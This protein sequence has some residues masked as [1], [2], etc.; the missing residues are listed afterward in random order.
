[1]VQAF[2]VDYLRQQKDASPRT[3]A[4]YRDTFRVLLD[5]LNTTTATP[6]CAL[7]L[8][9][10]DAPAVLRFLDY[11]ERERHNTARS[12]NARL[13]A[14]RSFFRF[15]ALREPTALA[16]AT[17]V[18]AIPAK[19]TKRSLVGYLSRAEIDAVLTAP[20]RSRRAGRRDHALLLTMY[21]T[22]ARVSEIAALCQGDVT[23]G[24]TAH[25]QL[26]GKGR[27]QRAV[28]IWPRT[29]RTLRLWFSEIRGGPSHPAFPNA[30][31]G[32]L[33]RHG[34]AFI[35]RRA[36]D[37]ARQHCPS[38]VNKSVSPHTIRHTTAMHL[39]Q[40]GVDPAVIALWLGH[41]SLETTHV[42]VEADLAMKRRALDKLSPAGPRPRSFTPSDSLL[43]FLTSL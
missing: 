29:A 32:P 24:A 25:L 42:Y 26:H 22:G 41:E 39:L 12:R 33:S 40:S 28:P 30:R 31:V 2:F 34:I 13:V 17:R 36:T 8:D 9:D 43:T 11:L 16:L 10:L 37:L 3:I 23:L 18:L 1:L 20:D 21:N 15:V 27:K 5:F 14:I 6:P 7:S 19:R 4:A 38:L 35:I